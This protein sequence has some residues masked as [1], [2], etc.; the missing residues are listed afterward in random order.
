MVRGLGAQVPKKTLDALY[1]ATEV[2][3]FSEL[4]ATFRPILNHLGFPYFCCVECISKPKATELKVLFGEPDHAWKDYYNETGLAEFDP[5]ISH[6][7][8]SVDPVILSDLAPRGN[9]TGHQHFLSCFRN[10]GHADCL[11]WPVHLPEGRVRAVVMPTAEP[12]IDAR[13]CATASA[14]AAGFHTAG[15]RLLRRAVTA[16]GA[17]ITLRKRQIECLYWAQRGKSAADIG[18]ILG[19]SARTVEEHIA[20]ACAI[21]GVRTRIQAV[22][23]CVILGIL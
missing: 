21:L 8:Y 12:K 4:N 23:R 1:A 14:L 11:V 3:S 9:D 2:S 7:L 13:T 18:A 10:Y 15:S 16:P 22:A 6:M 19:I 17:G 20:N 5:R